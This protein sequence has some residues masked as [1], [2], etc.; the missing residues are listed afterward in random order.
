MD[1]TGASRLLD[2]GGGGGAYVI[3][4][5]RQLPDLH[6]TVYDL[7]HV[8]DYTAER[9]DEAGLTGRIAVH[10]GDFFV[11]AEL[12]AGHDVILLSMI[13]HD[14]DEPRNREILAKCRRALP[15]GGLL[16]ISE[17]LVDD[18]KTAPADAALMSLNMLVGTPGRDSHG[19]GVLRVADRCRLRP[20][21]NGALRSAGADGVVLAR[22][23]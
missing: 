18:D 2:V 21:P 9:I 7:P 13:L 5:C 3:E 4:L 6:A 23:P 11:D 14:C 17:L 22:N 10:A 16:L 19:R 12:P 1:L 20:G 15:S 8:C